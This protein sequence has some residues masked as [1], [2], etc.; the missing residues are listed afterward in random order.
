MKVLVWQW[1]RFGGP[2]RFAA[3]LA[4][5]MRAQPGVTSVTL[6]LS[7]RAEILRT[8]KP[9]RCDLPV[10]TYSGF[11]SFAWK[12]LISP[13]IIVA[14]AR[15]LRAV[16]P[17]LAICAQPGPLDWVMAAALRPFGTRLMVIVHDA[18]LHPGDGMPLQMPLQRFLCRCADYIVALTGHVGDRLRAQGMAGGPNRPLILAAHPPVTFDVPPPRTSRDGPLHL[19]FFGRLMA[20]KGIDLLAGAL[21]LLGPR[22]D[23]AVRVVGLGDESPDLDTLRGQPNVTVENRWVEE[24]EVGALLG[25]SDALIL[26]YREASQS[27][28]AAAALAAGRTVIATNAGGLAEQLAGEA[29]AIM[30][31]PEVESVA[32]AVRT[33]LESPPRAQGSTPP[34]DQATGWRDLAATLLRGEAGILEVSPDD[35]PDDSIG[36]ASNGS[37]TSRTESGILPQ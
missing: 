14:L 2:P 10:D 33:L 1:S 28:V 26:P 16:R 5:G 22:P 19:L 35:P 31:E 8:A 15:R 11:G 37:M 27:G 7:T 18:D 24:D 17:D 36:E 29:L 32:A 21:A 4:E 25:W 13:V 20:Y 12:V 9:P 3:C 30:C 6:S 23:L 34:R